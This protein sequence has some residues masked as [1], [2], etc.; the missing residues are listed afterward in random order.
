M[1]GMTVLLCLVFGW[2][3]AGVANADEGFPGREEFPDIPIY[4]LGKLAEDFDRVTIVD[5][6]SRYEYETLRVQGARNIPVAS[7]KFENEILALRQKIDGPIVFYCNGRSCFKSY[8]AAKRSLAVGVRNVYAYDAG[9]FDWVK[10]Y[11]QRSELLGKGPVDLKSLIASDTFKSHLLKPEEF[12]S[13]ALQGDA[14]LLDVRDGFQRA[15]VGLFVGK[16]AWASLDDTGKLKK[17][18]VEASR[19]GSPLYIYDAVGKQVRWLQYLIEES[20]VS[21]YYFMERGA[22]GFYEDVLGV[23]HHAM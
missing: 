7:K 18:I 19:N 14:V 8:Q 5:V 16:E 10:A 2:F 12:S 21:E 9:V 4:E 1:R 11:P 6:R 20:K 23:T 3:G 13:R 17:L 22:K 15:G